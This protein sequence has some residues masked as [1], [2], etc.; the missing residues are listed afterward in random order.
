MKQ[1]KAK[2]SCRRLCGPHR[3]AEPAENRSVVGFLALFSSAKSVG[4]FG[5]VRMPLVS[6]SAP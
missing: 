6:N 5:A 2:A 4:R 3:P 1:E